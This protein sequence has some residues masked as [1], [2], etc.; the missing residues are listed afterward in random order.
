MILAYALILLVGSAVGQA[1]CSSEDSSCILRVLALRGLI[2]SQEGRQARA[3]GVEAVRGGRGEGR[4]GA[5]YRPD[6]WEQEDWPSSRGKRDVYQTT[7]PAP[8]T[9]GAPRGGRG[10]YRSSGGRRAPCLWEAS[11]YLGEDTV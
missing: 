1:P 7:E 3:E 11:Y 4:G 6:C 8:V 9:E 2:R 10:A 5:R